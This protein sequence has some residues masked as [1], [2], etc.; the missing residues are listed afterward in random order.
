MAILCKGK[1]NDLSWITARLLMAFA[2]IVLGLIGLYLVS[3]GLSATSNAV[4]PPIQ[5]GYY[6]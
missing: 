1:S 3:Q 6:Q 5:N 2:A 4:M